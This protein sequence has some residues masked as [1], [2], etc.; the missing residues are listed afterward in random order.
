MVEDCD[1]VAR[2]GDR[3][4]QAVLQLVSDDVV[5][6][7]AALRVQC[8]RGRDQANFFL[9]IEPHAGLDKKWIASEE[10]RV[11]SDLVNGLHV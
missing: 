8:R 7:A 3:G 1:P 2:R 9:N 4:A 11:R 6:N 5:S 10:P